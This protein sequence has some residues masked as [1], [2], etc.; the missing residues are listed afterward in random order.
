MGSCDPGEQLWQ[1]STGFPWCA[2]AALCR[3]GFQWKNWSLDLCAFSPWLGCVCI[4]L[5]H[6]RSCCHV[7]S[8]LFYHTASRLPAITINLGQIQH[9]IETEALLVLPR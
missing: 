3:D 4:S 6:V 7:V 8:W 1:G 5:I 9:G 2:W